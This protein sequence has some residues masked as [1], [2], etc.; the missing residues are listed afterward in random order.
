MGEWE[1]CA[2]VGL[3]SR[4]SHHVISRESAVTGRGGALN[5]MVALHSNWLRAHRANAD[6]LPQHLLPTLHP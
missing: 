1:L 2:V 6:E 3:D 5:Y 4:W